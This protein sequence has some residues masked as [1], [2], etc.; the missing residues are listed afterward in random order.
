MVPS[1]V[2]TL[3]SYLVDCVLY[4]NYVGVSMAFRGGDGVRYPPPSRRVKLKY[5][6]VIK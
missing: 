4:G 6:D 1:V 3:E 5:F 2:S